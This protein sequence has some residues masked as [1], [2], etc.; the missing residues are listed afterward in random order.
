MIKNSYSQ[1]EPT[2]ITKSFGFATEIKE[3]FGHTIQ[4]SKGM[5]LTAI[6]FGATITSL[7]IPLPNGKKKDV[8]LGFEKLEDYINSYNLPS[9]PYFGTVVGRYAGRINKGKFSIID[10]NVQLDKNNNENHLHGGK[11]G[12]SKAIWKA[13]KQ[14]PNLIC[15][16][17]TSYSYEDNYPGNLT[18]QVTYLLT[19]D[20][21][22]KIT[23]LASSTED[24]I[25]NL[26]QHSY[27]N[28]DGDSN[29]VLDHKL[30]I[31]SNLILETND[32]LIPT[33]NFISLDN[34]PFDFKELKKCPESIDTT[35]VSKTNEVGS[36][37]SEKSN[38]KMTV[39]SNQP[40][41]HIYVGGNCFNE[42]KG[43]N[44]IDY[45]ATSGICFENQNFPDAPNHSHFPCATL[46][47]NEKYFHQTLFKFEN[48]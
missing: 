32:E 15:F 48:I 1:I 41:V 38:L 14:E 9:A 27:F 22:L 28:L 34:H 46:Y 23:F 30:K 39:F 13:I 25:I 35:F 43:K 5:E 19:E 18:V 24:T 26:T 47:K 20:N 10:K 16:E 17:H 4:N 36:L 31:N 12:I 45:N 44:N 40:A 8:I 7:K 2:L 6:D 33:G 3:V 21:E 29:N 11:K 37:L 42:I